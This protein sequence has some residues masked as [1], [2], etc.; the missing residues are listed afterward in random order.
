MYTKHLHGDLLVV[1]LSGKVTID[2]IKLLASDI[3]ELAGSKEEIFVL[4]LMQS[5]TQFPQN[6]AQIAKAFQLVNT[7]TKKITRLYGIRYNAIV[8]YLSHIIT[9]VLR[10]GTNTVEAAT[11]EELFTLI[12]REAE[13]FPSLKASIRDLESIKAEVRHVQIAPS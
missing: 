4:A 12:E 11:V 5:A 7:A 1:I 3:D 13:V 9:Q 8:S 10:I 2:E 6:I